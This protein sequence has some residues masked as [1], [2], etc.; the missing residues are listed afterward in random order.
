MQWL[1]LW[2][3]FCRGARL[4]EAQHFLFRDSIMYSYSHKVF[5]AIS[6][7][8]AWQEKVGGWRQLEGEWLSVCHVTAVCAIILSVLVQQRF[9]PTPVVP[10]IQRPLL[11]CPSFRRRD[12]LLFHARHICMLYDVCVHYNGAGV[13]DDASAA[14]CAPFCP[15]PTAL[16]HP[17]DQFCK[18]FLPLCF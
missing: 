5:G 9:T 8:S 16:P 15:F 17:R 11:L 12:S 1:S 7:V 18:V 6:G 14:S 3:P 2:L 13:P 10:E 4:K